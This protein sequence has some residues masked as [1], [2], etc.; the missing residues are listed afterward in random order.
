MAGVSARSVLTSL[1]RPRG[2]SERDARAGER[3]VSVLNAHTSLRQRL[4]AL[5]KLG[6]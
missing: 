4:Q 1:T 5:T 6:T 3:V 2:P